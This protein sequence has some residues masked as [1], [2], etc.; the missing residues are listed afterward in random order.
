M[1]LKVLLVEDEAL[2]ALMAQDMI[3]GLGHEVAYTASSLKDA[4]DVCGRDF[5][6]ALLDV[7]LN[8]DSSM[9]VAASLKLHGRPFAFTTGYGAGGVD[10]EHRDAPVLGKPYALAE[11]ESMLDAFAAQLAGT[12]ST[13]SSVD[14]NRG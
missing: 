8:G 13:T 3:E 9:P 5:D 10:D 14:S 4:L 7:N 6:C 12:S 2:I 1:V 11:L